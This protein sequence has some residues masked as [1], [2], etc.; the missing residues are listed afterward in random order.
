M[1]MNATHVAFV[2]P[3]QGS[4]AVGMLSALAA[5]YPAVGA[6]FGEV[7]EVV[8]RDLWQLV[9][10]GPAADLDRTRNTQPALLAAGVAVWRCWQAAGGPEPA[11]MAGHSLGE[12]SALVC[13]EALTLTDAARLV[14]ERA[15]LMQ[16]AVPAEQGAMAAI[17]GL[18]DEE[19]IGLCAEQAGAEVLEAVN[20]NAPG[21]VVIAGARA[22]VERA[23]VAAKAAGA[24]RALALPVSV[25]AH[26][27]LMRPAAAA[28]QAVLADCPL[29]AP[30]IPVLH[31]V[32]VAPASD[33]D[34]LRDLLARQLYSPV[35]WV[36]TVQ[37]F[38]PR[39]IQ[40]VIEAGPGKVLTGLGKRIDDTLTFSA[41]FDPSGLETALAACAA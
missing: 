9:S 1:Y 25:P 28:F 36:E 6:T 39:G 17:L 14:A 20:F 24:K 18:A 26:C 27:A 10:M 40:H 22:A 21:Q 37:S 23:L 5:A 30:R 41:V 7:S 13:A 32:T 2:F 8:G 15:R 19:V 38:A 3:G 35:R 11:L 12:Y 16:D 4:Q 29:R 31:N 34:A 33:S